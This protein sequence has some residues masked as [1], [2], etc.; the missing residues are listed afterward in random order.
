MFALR[1]EKKQ[2]E[3]SLDWMS[4]L[5]VE[6]CAFSANQAKIFYCNTSTCTRG[7]AGLKTQIWISM[8]RK[9]TTCNT[10]A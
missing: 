8:R 6:N 3:R 9:V 7:D 5:L 4:Q 10:V 2:D 1:R